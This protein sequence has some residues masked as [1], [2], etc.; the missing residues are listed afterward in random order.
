MAI[1]AGSCRFGLWF[2]HVHWS[3]PVVQQV[4]FATTAID[5]PVPLLIRKYCAGQQVD[6]SALESIAPET[7]G[8][9]YARIYREVRAIP[10]GETATYGEI[11]RRADTGPRVVG[12]AMAKNPTPLVIPCHRVVGATGLGGFS[13]SLEIKETLLAMEKRGAAKKGGKTRIHLNAA[14]TGKVPEQRGRR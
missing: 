6:L 12:Q 4:R 3:G 5:G 8:E 10:Y 7:M 14:G 13:P 9:V 2:V 11:A 1:S